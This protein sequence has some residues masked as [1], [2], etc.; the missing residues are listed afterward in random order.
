MNL[1]LDVQAILVLLTVHFVAD[2]LLQSHWMASNKS[3]RMDALLLHTVT[4]GACFVIFGVWF[5][6][7]N[8][9]LHTLVDF[10][11][12]RITSQLWAKQQWHW[13]FAVVGADQLIHFFCLILTYGWFVGW[14][15]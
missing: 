1:P 4:Y 13:F 10:V 15:S 11:T 8:F 7:M 2:F 9:A 12:S 14:H 6:V 3:R 5:A